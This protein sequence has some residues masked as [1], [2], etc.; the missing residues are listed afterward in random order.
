MTT[1]TGLAHG[2]WHYLE[3]WSYWTRY[4]LV[5]GSVSLRTFEVLHVCLSLATVIHSPLLAAVGTIGS[6]S[7]LLQGHAC[8]D[9]ARLP[10]MMMM[11]QTFEPVSQAQLNVVFYKSCLGHGVSSQQWKA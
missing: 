5:R 11:G 1:G 3:V 2:K 10:A 4:S 9:T 8:L 6:S 7:H